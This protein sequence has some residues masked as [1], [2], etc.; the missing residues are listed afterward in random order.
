[1]SN[2]HRPFGVFDHS[3]D[4][5]PH[6]HTR[7]DA[8]QDD[9]DALD[10][11]LNGIS[12]ND[13]SPGTRSGSGHDRPDARTDEEASVIEAAARFHRRIEAAQSRDTRAAGPDPQL[14]E[15]IMER[16]SVPKAAPG[17]AST[18]N[19]WVAQPGSTTSAP[20]RRKRS[21]PKP[22]SMRRQQVW[23]TIANIG[24]VVAILLA[25]FGVW[26]YYGGPGLPGGSDNSPV[27]PQFAMQP[28]TPDVV[29]APASVE[30][31]VATPAPTTNCDF[32][33][34]I[35]IF[36]GVDE[37]PWNGTAVLLTTS[38]EVV[39]T[40]PAEPDGT[41]VA[42]GVEHATAMDWPGIVSLTFTE[43]GDDP[44]SQYSDKRAVINVMTGEMVR[45][46]TRPSGYHD[47]N[48]HP[49]SPWLVAPS[50]DFQGDWSIIDL[51]TMEEK[52]LSDY[53][54]DQVNGQPARFVHDVTTSANGNDDT[55]VIA[56]QFSNTYGSIIDPND[57]VFQEL[58]S[59]N[60]A[61]QYGPL[62]NNDVPGSLLVLDGSLDEARWMSLPRE[63][64]TYL[65]I[66]LSPDGQYM[67]LT[68]VDADFQ[69]YE[70]DGMGGAKGNILYSIM[71]LSDGAEVVQSLPTT[72]EAEE[73][74]TEMLWLADSSGL[75]YTHD[76]DV[77]VL[78]TD[79]NTEPYALY[80]SDNKLRSLQ[81]TTDPTRIL[82]SATPL[83]ELATADSQDSTPSMLS[84]STTGDDVIE[85]SGHIT[86]D[87][88][89]M[90]DLKPK[91]RFMVLR[92]PE[93]RGEQTTTYH[94]VDVLTGDIL[95]ELTTPVDVAGMG[96]GAISSTFD[97][98]VTVA[99]FGAQDIY[100][101]QT[102]DG[103]PIVH[104]LSTPDALSNPTG[105]VGVLVS[106][107]GARVFVGQ[108]SGE[109]QTV[110]VT[111]LADKSETWTAVP[112]Y[113]VFIPG[114]DD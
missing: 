46:G 71:R 14:W 49:G 64:Q 111:S 16:T 80:E 76:G 69:S 112:G 62:I 33:E 104:Q 4:H 22:G 15:T 28:A 6:R 68:S 96:K 2:P 89:Q 79:P 30:E 50:I 101:M 66:Q 58:A 45:I 67:A 42:S 35:P 102:V 81:P 52:P 90:Y 44:E 1:M 86:H 43:V 107:S 114:T 48:Q 73:Y 26:R 110:V 94:L 29:E 70:R 75:A 97:G 84:V 77:H 95:E 36:N 38:G 17:V 106:P 55:L 87:Y 113:P 47:L 8:S 31:P 103:D 3:D 51:R 41:E 11:W 19:P 10:A 83:N 74:G 82:V 61:M 98:K 72:G 9:A 18:A 54:S 108:T 60:L 37:S 40:C 99:T 12:R 78:P 59:V 92:Q 5:D 25:G 63:D 23:N 7:A 21:T 85:L 24:L 57:T 32:T 53:E 27:T 39:L 100:V 34:D 65:D 88:L 91:V 13:G 105:S 56:N 93:E 20:S 109:S